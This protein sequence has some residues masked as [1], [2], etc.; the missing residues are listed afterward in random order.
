MLRVCELMCSIEQI[1]IDINRHFLWWLLFAFLVLSEV[2]VNSFN[3]C[4][5]YLG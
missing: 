3:I 4:Y 1:L 5:K 2:T